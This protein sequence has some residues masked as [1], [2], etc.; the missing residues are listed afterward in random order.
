MNTLRK[1]DEQNYILECE[2]GETYNGKLWFEKKTGQ[3]H[4]KLPMPNP[5]NRQYIRISKIGPDGTYQFETK[6]PN[7]TRTI[8]A[9]SSTKLPGIPAWQTYLTEDEKVEL[10]NLKHRLL[11]LEEIGKSRT[12]KPSDLLQA[13]IDMLMAQLKELKESG[14]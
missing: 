14:R 11:E 8:K 1:I 12:P 10:A 4:V 2:N 13:K 3:Y 9:P 5:T 7:T 6:D